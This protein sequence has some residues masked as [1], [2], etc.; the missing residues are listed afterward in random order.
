MVHREARYGTGNVEGP[1]I[2]YIKGVNR[3]TN[4]NIGIK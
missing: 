1:E 3:I 4:I 2:N